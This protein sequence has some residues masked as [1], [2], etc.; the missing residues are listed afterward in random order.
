MRYFHNLINRKPETWLAT[1]T[2]KCRLQGRVLIKKF[3]SVDKK[4][5]LR[6]FMGDVRDL[7][8]LKFAMKN[9]DFGEFTSP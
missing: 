8:R 3:S 1:F 6:F 7:E 5:I 9:V 2:Y 4:G